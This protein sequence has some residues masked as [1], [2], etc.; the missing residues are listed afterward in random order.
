MSLHRFFLESPLPLHEGGEV[1][2]PLSAADAH[3]AASV[4]RL[5]T[6]EELEVAEPHG[7]ALLRVRLTAVEPHGL[8]GTVLARLE[9]SSQPRVTLVQGVAKGEKMD[10]VVRQ[11]VE[12]G[13]EEVLPVLTE[14]SIVRLDAR[15]AADRGERWR[16]IAKSA[17]EQ[18]H[19]DAVPAVHD[20]VTLVS[21]LPALA[22]YDRVV[23]LWEDAEG[24]GIDEALASLTFEGEPRV[25]LVVGPEGGL[26]APEVASLE[27]AGAVTATLGATI[28]RTETAAVAGLALA[29]HA[30]GGLGA[31]R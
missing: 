30:L 24:A 17:A 27:A 26:S 13:A 10:A 23:V 14:R 31:R 3:H 19:R 6:G 15:K 22:G 21:A 5:R 7:G 18:A 16:R 20:P 28:L 4:L 29:I 1:A 8:A 12:V 9:R 11:A 25:A 2:L